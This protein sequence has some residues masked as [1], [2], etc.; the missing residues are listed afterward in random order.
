MPKTMRLL[1]S[2]FTVSVFTTAITTGLIAP[3]PLYA[4]WHAYGADKASTKYAPLDQI[5]PDNFAKLQV[6]WRWRTADE[7]ILAANPDLW[8]MV[9]EATPIIVN[10]VLY[11]STSLSQVAAIDAQSG[12]TL[13]TYN[14]QT[15]KDGTPANLGFVHRG[16][17]YWADGDDQR[18]LIGTGDAY[19]IALNAADGKPIPGF[20][21]QGRIDLTKGLRRPIDRSLYA[22]SSP[23]N[24]CGDVAVVGATVLDAFAVGRPPEALMPP[25]DVR[26]FDVRTGEQRWVFQTVPQAGETGNETWKL[27]SWKTAGNANMWTWSSCDEELGYVYLPLST[28]TNDY[29]GGHR[30]GDNLFAESLV[31][32]NAASGERIWHFQAIHHG[33]WDYDLPAAPNL[34]DIRVDGKFIKAVA[35]ISKQGFCY[36]FDRVTGDPVWPILERP[37]PP[38]GTPGEYAS[39]TQPFPTKP[40]PFD[41][42][43]LSADD[44]I[45]FTPELHQEALQIISQYDYGPV[46][47]PPSEKGLIA[48]PGL[49]GGGNWAGAAVDPERGM[50]YIPSYTIPAIMTLKKTTEGTPYRYTGSYAWGPVTANGLPIVKPPY[51]RITAIDLN[52]GDHRWMSPVGDGPRH[53]PALKHL[54]LP[55]MGWG[56]RVFP[57]L[58]KTLLMAVMQGKMSEQEVS[59]R[60][61]A[62]LFSNETSE[63]Y[64]YAFDPA[65]GALLGKVELPANANGTPMTYTAGGKQYIVVPVGGASLPAELVA[66]SLP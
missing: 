37:V 52:S 12:K 35:Q 19:L 5:N 57:L 26:G 59:N 42:Q 39:P 47:T 55:P 58:T 44:L 34:V 62:M 1:H 10:G 32:L 64:L 54:D 41:R 60:S 53:H 16:V 50:I 40:A 9:N 8:T 23:P 65:N 48:M 7:A 6:A 45:D 22:L 63:P 29:Y 66:L 24:V 61:N 31:C 33:M 2:F 51:A 20:G 36:V 3:N 15:Y 30:L 56:R 46:F 49:V 28:P 13:W 14:P 11:V 17:A 43:G 18:I 21:D 25:G 38:S 27:E 4:Q